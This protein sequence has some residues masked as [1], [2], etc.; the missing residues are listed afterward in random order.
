MT[1]G[2][3]AFAILLPFR[4][5]AAAASDTAVIVAGVVVVCLAVIACVLI[6]GSGVAP[7][8][9]WGSLKLEFERLPRSRRRRQAPLKPET[10]KQD[11]D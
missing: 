10:T 9:R 8:F 11:P 7:R 4:F 6:V 5:L 3:C 2:I 1:F